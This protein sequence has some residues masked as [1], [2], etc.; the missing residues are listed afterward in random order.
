M[1]LSALAAIVM[2]TVTPAPAFAD[3]KPWTPRVDFHL[4]ARPWQPLNISREAYLDSIEGI[5]RFTVKHL[6]PRGEVIDPFLKREHQ[7]S[8]P[9]FAF[10]VGTLVKAGRAK[11]LL[12]HGVAAM[13][14][15]TNCVAGGRE[16]IPDNHG[17]FF[18]PCLAGAIEIYEGL[19][20]RKTIE[21][22]RLR[23]NRPIEEIV[24]GKSNN[25]RAYVMRGQ[26]MRA[27]LGIVDRKTATDYIED[28]WR[29]AE[30]RDRIA[31]DAWNLYQDHQTD[32]ESHAV[33]AVGRGNLLGLIAQGYDG[34]SAREMREFVERETAVSLLLQDPTGQC[35]PDGRADDHVFNDVLYQ[36]CFDVMAQ[37]A[38]IAGEQRLAGQY[39][40]VVRVNDDGFES[41]LGSVRGNLYAGR[42]SAGGEG[43]A[44]DCDGDG[45]DDV[46]FDREC[47]FVLQLRDGQSTAMEADRKVTA[48]IGG[49]RF[50]LKSFEPMTLSTSQRTSLHESFDLLHPQKLWLDELTISESR[51]ASPRGRGP[52]G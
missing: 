20:P 36:L 42:T 38:Q 15:A 12:P 44:I 51:S 7:Y 39:Q 5:C 46:T 10:A 14:H 24:N 29:N 17:E 25:W 31:G 26:W 4:T 3:D 43:K 8:T 40:D 32:P 45:R 27:K 50:K 2:L 48:S 9:Y 13:E 21:L 1:K 47:R 41:K 22:W 19:V 18:I 6:G 37:R 28:S 52:R 11:D 35:P 49:K 34:P 16:T 30:Q 23:I 33:E